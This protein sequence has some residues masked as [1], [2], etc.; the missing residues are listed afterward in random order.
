MTRLGLLL[1]VAAFALSLNP[2]NAEDP[3]RPKSRRMP[4][5]LWPP[6]SGQD[7]ANLTEQSFEIDGWHYDVRK[8]ADT[9]GG[10]PWR[11][12]ATPVDAKAWRQGSDR[13]GGPTKTAQRGGGGTGGGSFTDASSVPAATVPDVL[14]KQRMSAD[15]VGD[16]K[17]DVVGIHFH[18][19]VTNDLSGILYTLHKVPPDE[20]DGMPAK[21]K[22][23]VSGTR[24]EATLLNPVIYHLDQSIAVRENPLK[25]DA[26]P[27]RIA[28][29]KGHAAV[30]LEI[31]PPVLAGPQDWEP[32]TCTG[33]RSEVHYYWKREQIG[34]TWTGYDRE[35]GKLASQRT[36]L[37]LVPPTRW[38][39]M[40]PVPPE[41]VTQKQIQA[42][43]DSIVMTGARFG[44]L[45]R[46][47]QARFHAD[48]G[49]F[50][51]SSP[52]R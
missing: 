21:E 28:H 52:D 12:V 42:F 14:W 3:S 34:R 44:K 22:Q 18:D 51:S 6:S 29:E 32:L 25:K 36:T 19:L 1:C 43:N 2:S 5:T 40:L 15:L 50:E 30:S 41:R 24:I 49:A 27:V 33:R 7:L 11:I 48:H 20:P 31:L 10:V 23:G 26:T 47:A 37:V 9:R 13:R 45:D 16:D 8:S 35:R 38:S 4:I 46:V 17:S 39:L